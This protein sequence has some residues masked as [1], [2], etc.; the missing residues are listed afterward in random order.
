M[1]SVTRQEPTPQRLRIQILSAAQEA[2][3]LGQSVGDF[4]ALASTAHSQATKRAERVKE[5]EQKG[6][7]SC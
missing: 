6:G 4:L 5:G 2:V 1:S 7:R 3:A